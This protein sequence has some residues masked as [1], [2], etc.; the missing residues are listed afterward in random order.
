MLYNINKILKMI[1]LTDILNEARVV[2]VGM[3]NKQ[4]IIDDIWEFNP[5]LIESLFRNPT[6]DELIKDSVFENTNLTDWL[7][8]EFDYDEDSPELPKAL[9]LIKT[10]YKSIQP[11]E[12]KILNMDEG[13]VNILGYKHIEEM[14]PQNGECFIIAT[15]F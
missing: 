15:K 11:G 10:Y 2:P 3:T 9:E 5:W 8:G 13:K 7:M 12:I 14:C 4:K 1:K 6:P